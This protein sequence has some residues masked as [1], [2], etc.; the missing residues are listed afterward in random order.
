MLG[1][2]AALRRKLELPV[3]KYDVI[4]EKNPF[5]I[6]G[7]GLT[8]YFHTMKSLFTL[9]FILM[10]ASIP[11]MFLYASYGDLEALPNYYFNQYSL[12]NMGGSKALCKGATVIYDAI[13]LPL[14]CSTGVI[15]L[16][17]LDD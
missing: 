14:S 1:L 10:L 5:L 16:D 3:P 2:K 12:G 6:L 11:V 9:W 15:R 13:P 7:Y 4:I 8:S 17:A